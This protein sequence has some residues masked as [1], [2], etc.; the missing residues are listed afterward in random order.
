MQTIILHHPQHRAA[1]TRLVGLAPE[2]SVVTV[3]PPR[4]S[5]DQNAKMWAML[6]EWARQ[7][8]HG[9]RKYDAETWKA[10]FMR[11]LGHEVRMVPDLRGEPFPVGFRS[12][13]LSKAQMADLI[14]FIQSEA[15]ARG[16]D[17]REPA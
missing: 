4:R 16:V 14:T 3:S 5:L 15:D 9:G 10:I 11:A 1:A 6:G 12:S 17:L 8:D 2:G 13:H 7:V